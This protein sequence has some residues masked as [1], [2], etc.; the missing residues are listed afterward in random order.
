MFV[1]GGDVDPGD[2]LDNAGYVGNYWSSVG[3]SS[4]YAYYLYFGPSGVRPSFRS[5]R[6]FGQSVRCV[7]LGG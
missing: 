5:P 2:F 3:Y 1:R 7:A 6:Y 4:G